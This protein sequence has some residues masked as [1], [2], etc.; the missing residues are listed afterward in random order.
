MKA[1]PG[2]PP[3]AWLGAEL[4]RAAG[5]VLLLGR[6]SSALTAA[7]GA[8]LGTSRALWLLSPRG[9]PWHGAGHTRLPGTAL[10][11]VQGPAFGGELE[12]LQPMRN[13]L[14]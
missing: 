1:C 9:H 10:L 2:F 14:G 13:F 5:R 6:M 3:V 7:P 8:G 11:R 12:K 4:Q